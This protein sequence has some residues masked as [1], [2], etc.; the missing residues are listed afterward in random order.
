MLNKKSVTHEA[1]WSVLNSQ[2]SPPWISNVSVLFALN[3]PHP[4]WLIRVAG[5]PWRLLPLAAE[6]LLS[7]A[8]L[9]DRVG[10]W[11]T[12]KDKS[13]TAKTSN[14]YSHDKHIHPLVLRKTRFNKVN[15]LHIREIKEYD[16]FALDMSVCQQFC[17][18]P[19]SQELLWV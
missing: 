12:E 4:H 19:V 18:F 7:E 17:I 6:Q 1:T 13:L 3:E 5:L 2:W 11:G 15:M 9:D 8:L 10:L 16:N 14:V